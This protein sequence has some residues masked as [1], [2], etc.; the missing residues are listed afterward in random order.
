MHTKMKLLTLRVKPFSAHE[1]GFQILCQRD[2]Q[3]FFTLSS[4]F[5]SDLATSAVSS[6]I[7]VDRDRLSAN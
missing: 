5:F 3:V 2:Y 6:R 7:N 4:Y 1:T